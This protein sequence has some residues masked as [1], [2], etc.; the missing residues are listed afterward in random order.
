VRVNDYTHIGIEVN[1][2]ASTRSTVIASPAQRGEAISH[3]IT[4]RVSPELVE[5]RIENL[6]YNPNVKC[7]DLTPQLPNQQNVEDWH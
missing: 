1:A 6:C 2:V 3:D 5:G 4:V 7:L